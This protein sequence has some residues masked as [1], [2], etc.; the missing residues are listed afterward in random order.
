MSQRINCWV[1]F[2][3]LRYF[4]IFFTLQK[5]CILYEYRGYGS[6]PFE[7]G[8]MQQECEKCLQSNT[9]PPGP[10]QQL[11]SSSLLTPRDHAGGRDVN[12]GILYRRFCLGHA[13]WWGAVWEPWD[14]AWLEQDE[15]KIVQTQCKYHSSKREEEQCDP[16]RRVCSPV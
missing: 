3:S 1:F 4:E 15:R 2:V 13:F 6:L 11:L 9:V 8:N 14:H 10:K 16:V 7:K 5:K 12:V